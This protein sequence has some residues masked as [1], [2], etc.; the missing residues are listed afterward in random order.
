MDSEDIPNPQRT[1]GSR[2]CAGLLGWRILGWRHSHGDRV[3]GVECG[4]DREWTMRGIK[5][6]LKKRLKDKIKDLKI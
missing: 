3:G 6:V 1:G 4:T 5:S 2:E